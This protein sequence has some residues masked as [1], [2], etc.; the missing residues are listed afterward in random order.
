MKS[1]AERPATR[2]RLCFLL[3][4]SDGC[5]DPLGGWHEPFVACHC[6]SSTGNTEFWTKR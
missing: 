1:I 4:D 5:E 2:R 6:D 3:L